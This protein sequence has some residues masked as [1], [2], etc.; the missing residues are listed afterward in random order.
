[1]GYYQRS[2]TFVTGEQVSQNDPLFL[3]TDGTVKICDTTAGNLKKF[4]GLAATDAASGASVAVKA[5]RVTFGA[6]TTIVPGQRIVL[7]SS[8]AKKVLP[9]DSDSDTAD[10]IIGFAVTGATGTTNDLIA[11]IY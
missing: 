7:S 4:V 11:F 10:Q 2:M 8:V 5:G 1:M 6:G 9:F 3:H